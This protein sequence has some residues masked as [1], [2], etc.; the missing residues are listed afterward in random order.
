[1]NNL[2]NAVTQ[3]TKGLFAGDTA[4]F[5]DAGASAPLRFFRTVS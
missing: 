1:M 5:F 3:I 4:F 2:S